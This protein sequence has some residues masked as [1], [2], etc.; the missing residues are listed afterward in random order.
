[1][2]PGFQSEEKY[3]LETETEYNDQNKLTETVK[4]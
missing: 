4:N 2:V 1:M 3:T